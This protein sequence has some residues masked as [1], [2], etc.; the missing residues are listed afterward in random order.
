MVQSF[1]ARMREQR[2]RQQIPLIAI[3]ERTKIKLSLLEALEQDDVSHWPTGIFRRAFI[4]AYASAIELDPDVAVRE[5]LELYP[6][7]AEA[8]VPVPALEPGV[9]SADRAPLRVR[10]L[11]R[12]ALDTMSRKWV[13]LAGRNRPAPEP[14][15]MGDRLMEALPLDIPERPDEPER[16]N[17]TP[18]WSVDPSLAGT[19][20]PSP[21]VFEELAEA[22]STLPNL[23][24]EFSPVSDG[25]D[26]ASLLEHAAGVLEAV[27]VVVW[28]W[29]P[30]ESGLVPALAH[31]YS[32]QLLAQFPSVSRDADNATA[33]AFRSTRTCI[34]PSTK[35]ASGAVVVPMM[36]PAGCVGVLAVELPRGAELREPV[37]ALAT[38]LAAQFAALLCARR[39][40]HAVSA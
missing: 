4:R 5:F 23:P 7:P 24:P 40:R 27:G 26:P 19:P 29:D 28:K 6:D 1:G 33:A 38:S 10:F 20:V 13:D 21:E 2:E 34:V 8:L 31:G 37:R 39:L 32:D 30:K 22:P 11:I 9:M 12:S 36:T 15:P 16:A 14:P 35:A 18:V 3:S 17:G 25:Q